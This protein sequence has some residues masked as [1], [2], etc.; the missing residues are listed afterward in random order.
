MLSERFL[1]LPS[2]FKTSLLFITLLCWVLLQSSRSLICSVSSSLPLNPSWSFLTLSLCWSSHCVHPFSPQVL[3]AFFPLQMFT[4]FL[5]ERQSVSGGRAERE[6]DTE[7]EAGSRLWA[8]STEPDVGLELVKREI[9]T[10]AE[11]GHLT[12]WATQDLFYEHFYVH[13]LKFFFRLLFSISLRSF[14]E[15]S[16]YSSV[17][18]IVLGFFILLDSR[19]VS[20]Y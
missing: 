19:C 8:V 15:V 3:W 11:V 16:S 10:W 9:M 6:G 20:M 18:N 2:F 14:S 17:W 4:H 5:R 12:D 7:C 1:K 13:Y